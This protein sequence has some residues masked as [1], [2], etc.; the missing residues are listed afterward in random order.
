MGR[1]QSKILLILLIQKTSVQHELWARL[2]QPAGAGVRGLVGALTKSGQ[3]PITCWPIPSSSEDEIREESRTPENHKCC[4]TF[5]SWRLFSTRLGTDPS[6][7][8]PS[9]SHLHSETTP[10]PPP[11]DKGWA[12]PQRGPIQPMIR[13]AG[14][15]SRACQ[16]APA[17]LQKKSEGKKK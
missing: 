12:W 6:P 10:P 16:H 15:L 9:F 17:A 1:P 7:F 4:P 14:Y 8:N 3:T 11:A 2:V 13:K 5:C